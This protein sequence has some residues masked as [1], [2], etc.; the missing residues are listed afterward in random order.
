M[1]SE[2][3]KA[4]SGIGLLIALFLFLRYGS[5]FDQIVSSIGGFVQG[6]TSILQ[7]QSVAA[8]VKPVATNTTAGTIL[9]AFGL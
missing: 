7:G 1:G 3:G 2:V 8:G 4:I 9:A 5:A 6:E